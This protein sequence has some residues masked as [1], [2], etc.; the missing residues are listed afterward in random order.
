[1]ES[2]HLPVDRMWCGPPLSTLIRIRIR[3]TFLENWQAYIKTFCALVPPLH[4]RGAPFIHFA[5]HPK[6]SW[7][8]H[9]FVYLFSSIFFSCLFHLSD[10][11]YFR[12]HLC[13]LFGFGLLRITWGCTVFWMLALAFYRSQQ[14]SAKGQQ[15]TFKFFHN[16]LR[17]RKVIFPST[18]A[19]VT[20]IW[21]T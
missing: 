3:N 12:W 21:L 17:L 5:P 2:A 9:W 8:R 7:V 19:D 10:F 16:Q 15:I 13:V 6:K 4:T 11:S 1:M 18:Y 20:V 14:H